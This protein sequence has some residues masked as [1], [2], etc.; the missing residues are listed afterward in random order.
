MYGRLRE[1]VPPVSR[2]VRSP[3]I[4]DTAVGRSEP[5]LASFPACASIARPWPAVRRHQFPLIEP[6]VQ[7][8]RIRLSW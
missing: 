6:D 7:I 1:R 2:A 8:S 3:R 5:L 4:H